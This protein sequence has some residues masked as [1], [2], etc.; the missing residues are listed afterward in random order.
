MPVGDKSHPPNLARLLRERIERPSG[1]D[2]EQDDEF[3]PFHE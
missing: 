2:A 1:R 3:A